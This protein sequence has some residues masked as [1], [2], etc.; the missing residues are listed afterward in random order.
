MASIF[1]RLTPPCLPPSSFCDLIASFLAG[2]LAARPIED[3]GSGGA[4]GSHRR[5]RDVADCVGAAAGRH[6]NAKAE[7]RR[8]SWSASELV[9]DSPHAGFTGSRRDFRLSNRRAVAANDGRA[10][11]F[12][13]APRDMVSRRPDF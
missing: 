1:S 8:G 9:V 5:G 4:A 10:A 13:H 7:T 3:A 11:G 12:G 2:A 6:R